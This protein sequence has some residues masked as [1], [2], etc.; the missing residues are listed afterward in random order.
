[1][2]TIN[3]DTY[4]I[5]NI[6]S[7]VNIDK[8]IFVNKYH[9]NKSKKELKEKV[10]IIENFYLK[11]K[12]RLEMIFEYLDYDNI[13][14]IRNYY[15]LFYPKEFRLYFI[16]YTLLYLNVP[17]NY[18]INININKSFINLINILSINDLVSLGW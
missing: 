6:L 10:K 15:I 13:T 16:H 11:N 9:Y 18:N 4:I 3:L 14:A 17:T 2:N 8:K 12:L 1:M 5:N 7:Y